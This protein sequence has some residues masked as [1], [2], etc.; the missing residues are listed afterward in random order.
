M[1]KFY[2]KGDLVCIALASVMLTALI[3]LAVVL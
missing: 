2:N 1:K 3:V